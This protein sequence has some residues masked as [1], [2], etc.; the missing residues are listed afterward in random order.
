M[1]TIVQITGVSFSNARDAVEGRIKN[2]LKS[3]PL[4]ENEQVEV[5]F[6]ANHA[7]CAVTATVDSTVFTSLV[8]EKTG[9]RIAKGISEILHK[10]TDQSGCLVVLNRAFVIAS[11]GDG[12]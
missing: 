6:G 8:D 4:T 7:P 2:Y 12:V 11:S 10:C 9:N 3:I 5:I 1:A